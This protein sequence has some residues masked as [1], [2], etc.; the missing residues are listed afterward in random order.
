[1]V[2]KDIISAS[3]PDEIVNMI[4]QLGLNVDSPN[5]PDGCNMVLSL[6]LLYMS[7]IDQNLNAR[8]R[9]N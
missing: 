5:L 8:Y 7:R 9:H 3:L 2:I 6:M 1:M 4:T